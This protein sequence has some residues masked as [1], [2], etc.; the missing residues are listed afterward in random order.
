MARVKPSGSCVRF[1]KNTKPV[2]SA[3]YRA[4]V[5]KL[6]CIVTGQ[7]GVEAAHLSTA[8]QR[9]AHNGRGKSQKASDR[10][11]LPLASDV[12]RRQHEAN[13]LAFWECH[14]INPYVACLVL[15]GLYSDGKDGAI[16]QASA[17]IQS[18]IFHMG[19]PS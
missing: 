5:K 8:S 10:W 13:E 15:H 18:R 6:P 17:L 2:K 3:D 12:H 19:Y 11:V 7:S 1:G 9:Y 4:W 14:G 16:D